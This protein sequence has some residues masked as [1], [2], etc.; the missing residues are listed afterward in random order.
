[1]LSQSKGDSDDDIDEIAAL[2][3]S[4]DQIADYKRAFDLF[5]PDR[6]G[7]ITTLELGTVMRV[8]GQNPTEA[9][10]QD[11]VNEVDEDGNGTIEF[12][13]FVKMMS[14]KSA[15]N[16][17]DVS[18]EAF[19]VFDPEKKGYITGPGLKKV[20]MDLGEELNDEEVEEMMRK[21]DLNGDGRIDFSEFLWMIEATDEDISKLKQTQTV[22]SKRKEPSNALKEDDENFR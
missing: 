4:E 1:M 2:G 10:L 15:G 19:D 17:K 5:D 22:G 18:R 13:E 12:N 8:I 9:E 14:S 20:M 11:M 16:A 3:L 7:T 6:D 21:V